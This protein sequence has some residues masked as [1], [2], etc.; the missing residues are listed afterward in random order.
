MKTRIGFV[1]NS[2][3][4]SFILAVKGKTLKQALQELDDYEKNGLFASIMGEIINTIESNSKLLNEES[5]SYE[6]GYDSLEE[7]YLSGEHNADKI[8]ELYRQGFKVYVGSFSDEDEPAEALLCN[9]DLN[10]KSPNLVM[11]H[12]GGY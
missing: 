12:E 3:S 8:R 2:S 11:I 10:Y 5:V 9:M 4:S 7:F 6:M 1:S